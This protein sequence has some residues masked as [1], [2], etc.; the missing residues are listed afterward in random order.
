MNDTPLT[1]AQSAADSVVELLAKI[2]EAHYIE[3]WGLQTKNIELREQIE[4]LEAELA[5]LKP[6][7]HEFDYLDEH[8]TFAEMF[9]PNPA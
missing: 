4:D 2:K 6:E 5:K 7:S 8:R 3:M 1:L 9:P